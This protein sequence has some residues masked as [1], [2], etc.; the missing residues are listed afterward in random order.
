MIG[1]TETSLCFSGFVVRIKEGR[2]LTSKNLRAD[3]SKFL[4]EI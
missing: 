4:A 3:L 1:K 2:F